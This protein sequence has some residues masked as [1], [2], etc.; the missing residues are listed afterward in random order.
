MESCLSFS[1]RECSATESSK[2]IE[3]WY[4]ISNSNAIA[5]VTSH[6]IVFG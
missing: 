4:V 2:I 5:N 6:P 1:I 3:I